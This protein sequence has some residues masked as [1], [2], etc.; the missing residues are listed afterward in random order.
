MV[1]AIGGGAKRTLIDVA[2]ILLV[3]V[4]IAFAMV[5]VILGA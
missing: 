5:K 2:T 3:S 1:K 4:W